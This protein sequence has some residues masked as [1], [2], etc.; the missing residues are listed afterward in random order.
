M[1]QW[2]VVKRPLTFDLES[3]LNHQ[4]YVKL[5]RKSDLRLF[6]FIL[7]D[8]KYKAK[9][10]TLLFINVIYTLISTLEWWKAEL[11]DPPR[12]KSD[13]HGPPCHSILVYEEFK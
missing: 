5:E 6:I 10:S 7:T 1:E 4:F 12:P 11:E 13:D 3:F 9:Y 8:N 2:F